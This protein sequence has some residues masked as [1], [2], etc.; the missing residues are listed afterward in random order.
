MITDSNQA[1]FAKMTGRRV[2][3]AIFVP[4]CMGRVRFS[5][6]PNWRLKKTWVIQLSQQRAVGVLETLQMDLFH[7]TPLLSSQTFD[8]SK[9]AVP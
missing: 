2:Q 4:G 1:C 8:S 9:D 3:E 7:P 5:L 6:Y